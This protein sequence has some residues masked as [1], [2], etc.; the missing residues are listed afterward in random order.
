M[1]PRAV[2]SR[3]RPPCLP[4]PLP[5][6][7]PTCRGQTVPPELLAS[8]PSAC[9]LLTCDQMCFSPGPSQGGPSC[10]AL[11]LWRQRTCPEPGAGSDFKP[12]PSCRAWL[13]IWL[14]LSPSSVGAQNPQQVLSHPF[15]GSLAITSSGKCSL[16]SPARLRHDFLH[17]TVTLTDRLLHSSMPYSV[18]VCV[19]VRACVCTCVCT[20]ACVCVCTSVSF[21]GLESGPLLIHLGY[22][23][24]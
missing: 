9:P 2:T 24:A 14:S 12:S 11:L 7:R 23:G 17:S 15:T 10:F 1:S 3:H 19:C 16:I 6:N 18:R 8:Y 22:S 5:A 20:R 13:A 21:T 4:I